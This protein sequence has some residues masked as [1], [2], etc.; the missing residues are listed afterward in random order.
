M[1]K[2]YTAWD[3]AK[4]GIFTALYV[5]VGTVSMCHAVDFMCLTSV[6]WQGILLAV[7][8]ELTQAYTLFHILTSVKNTVRAYILMSLATLV[9]MIGN[10]FACYKFMRTDADSALSYFAEIVQFFAEM[11]NDEPMD[12]RTCYITIS[13]MI[14]ILVPSFALFLTDMAVDTIKN[15][16]DFGKFEEETPVEKTVEETKPIEN[17]ATTEKTEY[18]PEPKSEP[19]PIEPVIEDKTPAPIETKKKTNKYI[20]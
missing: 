18:E 17:I 10:V 3:I 6:M 7:A 14:G 9:Q 1:N 2:K 8:F 20:L 16:D 11:I 13:M 4:I 15:K 5:I 19:E 12:E